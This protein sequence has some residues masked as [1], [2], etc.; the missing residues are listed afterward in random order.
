MKKVGYKKVCMITGWHWCGP[1]DT[2]SHAETVRVHQTLVMVA[3]S[4]E[5]TNFH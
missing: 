4:K 5:E 1:K 2:H 3:S